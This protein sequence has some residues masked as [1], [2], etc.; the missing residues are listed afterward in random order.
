MRLGEV[1]P[2]RPEDFD[3]KTLGSV[4]QPHEG[5]ILEGTKTDHREGTPTAWSPYFSVFGSERPNDCE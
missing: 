3:G 2:L 4:V 1:L 5:R